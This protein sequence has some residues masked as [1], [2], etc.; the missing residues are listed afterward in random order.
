M[1]SINF[2]TDVRIQGIYRHPPISGTIPTVCIILQ[3]IESGIVVKLEKAD[4]FDHVLVDCQKLLEHEVNVYY[5]N[6]LK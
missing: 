5:S 3:H 2:K 6:N 4:V 1:K